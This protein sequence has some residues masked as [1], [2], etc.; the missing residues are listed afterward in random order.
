MARD[1]SLLE[2]LLATDIRAEHSRLLQCMRFFVA[3]NFLQDVG[4]KPLLYP[5]EPPSATEQPPG[6][7]YSAPKL[8]VSRID[9]NLE[10]MLAVASSHCHYVAIASKHCAS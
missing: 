8:S 9:V 2:K 5:P 7:Y 3:N 6:E 4:S 10:K 1:P